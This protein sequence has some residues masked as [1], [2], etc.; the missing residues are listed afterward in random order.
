[1]GLVVYNRGWL[2]ASR[3]GADTSRLLDA[4]PGATQLPDQRSFPLRQGFAPDAAIL[5]HS[6]VPTEQ[7]LS[8]SC[9]SSMAK[10]KNSPRRNLP[11]GTGGLAPNV[12]TSATRSSRRM[13]SGSRTSFAATGAASEMRW[14]ALNS[15]AETSVKMGSGATFTSDGQHLIY[16]ISADTAGV[17]AGGGAA[18]RG[19]R[20]GRGGAAGTAA[21]ANH[22]KAGIV[23]LRTGATIILDD[24]QSFVVSADGAHV[25]LRRYAPAGRTGHGGDLVVRD[26]ETASDVTLGNVDE[27]AWS[28]DGALLAM[29]I[30]VDGKTGTECSC[31]THRVAGSGRSTPATP[32]CREP[33]ARR[34]DALTL[35]FSAV[36]A[37]TARSLATSATTPVSRSAS[38]GAATPAMRVWRFRGRT[39]AFLGVDIARRRRTGGCS[40]I[41]D[42]QHAVLRRRTTRRWSR[43]RRPHR[44]DPARWYPRA[45]RSGT[46]RTPAGVSHAA[47]EHAQWI[48]ETHR[49]RGMAHRAERRRAPLGAIRTT[50][51][52]ASPNAQDRDSRPTKIPISRRSFHRTVVVDSTLSASTSRQ[53]IAKR[54]RRRPRSP[55]S[56]SPS[57]RVPRRLKR[58]PVVAPRDLAGGAAVSLTGKIRVLCDDD[59]DPPVPWNDAPTDSPAG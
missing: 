52:P 37:R 36:A 58:R 59:D 31:S 46:G 16:T 2:H 20:G 18:G 8:S 25:A 13:A 9:W 34:G 38:L 29:T 10:V 49:P 57:G 30:D 50:E 6:P 23:D 12:E 5:R 3:P 53:D 27:Y 39:P 1:M 24:I 47:G 33:P 17:G 28:T 15:D 40:G 54:S 14:H 43:L 22:N 11:V 32:D 21:P 41:D 45:S 7:R 56:L 19:G 26:L 48:A 55:R 35:L 44:H 51:D 4:I 42:G